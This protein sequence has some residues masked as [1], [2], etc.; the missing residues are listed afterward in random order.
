M[1]EVELENK[2]SYAYQGEEQ[3]ASKV[4]LLEPKAIWA[5]QFAEIKKEIN[6]AIVEQ[7]KIESAKA[8]KKIEEVKMSNEELGSVMMMLVSMHA[9]P[10]V[11][12]S[13]FEELIKSGL[14]KVA[15]TGILFTSG[16]FDKLSLKDFNKIVESY[17]GNFMKP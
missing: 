5:R 4:I 9:D 16:M 10:V 7:N 3:F 17:I 13:K 2:I 1:I 6:K 11:V 8:D 14:I 12:Y 15:D